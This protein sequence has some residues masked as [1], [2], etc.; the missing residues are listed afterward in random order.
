M[1]F[2]QLIVKKTDQTAAYN[3][4]APKLG[5]SDQREANQQHGHDKHE[6]PQPPESHICLEYVDARPGQSS[7]PKGWKRGRP[8]AIYSRPTNLSPLH[9]E[10]WR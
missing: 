8:K 2:S 9:W 4:M 7:S 5:T 6:R 1:N 10:A 3:L